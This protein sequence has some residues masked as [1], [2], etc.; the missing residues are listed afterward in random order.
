MKCQVIVLYFA[1]NLRISWPIIRKKNKENKLFFP[2]ISSL[3]YCG[4]F[5]KSYLWKCNFCFAFSNVEDGILIQI[6]EPWIIVLCIEQSQIPPLAKYT[7]KKYNYK[8]S[9]LSKHWCLIT[10]LFFNYLKLY[11]AK[12]FY[13]HFKIIVYTC[14]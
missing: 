10:W 13:I 14:I 8:F 1:Y 4:L 9:I 12:C 3:Y 5:W 7:N 2:R 6:Y 11:Q